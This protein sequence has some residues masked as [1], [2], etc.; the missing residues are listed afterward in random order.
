MSFQEKSLQWFPTKLRTNLQHLLVFG[1]FFVL[2]A[3][4]FVLPNTSIPVGTN[5][6]GAALG[7]LT[8][9]FAIEIY[10][11]REDSQK[12]VDLFLVLGLVLLL[13]DVATRLSLI[14][15]ILF[16]TP[17]AVFAVYSQDYS[18]II[19]GIFSSLSILGT[20]YLFAVI[21]A[22]PIGLVIGWRKR[23]YNVAYPIAKVASPVPPIVY[24]PYAIALLPSFFL[25]STF[26]IFIGAFW[27]ILVGV[28]YGVFS[29]D[30]RILNS[31]KTLGLDEITIMKKV[32]LPGSMQSI[33][34]GALIGLIISFITL[35]A[36]E[37]V[38]ASSGLG[39]YIQY[40]SQFANYD[41]VLA[42]MIVLAIVVIFITII[43]DRVQDYI[44][45]WQNTN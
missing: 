9:L 11:H 44:L 38:G 41:G 12:T 33:F 30:H 6:F 42:G 7:L 8:L 35:T 10:I 27:P 21:L 16:P 28:I 37:I 2:F 20:G 23:V 36:A 22:V 15:T 43:F 1:I 19:T 4:T 29:I 5:L 3:I 34:S 24:M 32:L 14:D 25:S 26:L 45:R 17:E 40:Q 39:W 13:W 31:A 18:N